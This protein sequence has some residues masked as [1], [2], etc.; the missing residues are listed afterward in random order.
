MDENDKDTLMNFVGQ[1]WS[2]FS[3]FCE[4]RGEDPQRIYEELGGEP[5]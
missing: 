1:Y 4:E 3:D 5:E 2:L